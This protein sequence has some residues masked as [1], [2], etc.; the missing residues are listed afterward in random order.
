MDPRSD[1]GYNRLPTLDKCRKL[2]E[3]NDILVKNFRSYIDYDNLTDGRS[4]RSGYGNSSWF[5][6][7]WQIFTEEN[8]KRSAFIRFLMVHSVAREEF[9]RGGIHR[10]EED[11]AGS[12]FEPVTRFSSIT[13]YCAEMFPGRNNDIEKYMRANFV[14]DKERGLLGP[15]LTNKLLLFAPF[16]HG[17]A[18]RWPD[19][20]PELSEAEQDDESP[21][22]GNSDGD[23]TGS[24]D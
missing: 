12:G 1:R 24:G 2:A 20:E 21:Q 17:N 13:E 8:P 4:L 3:F 10:F 16:F 6:P 22:E 7:N 23:A 9:R 14:S 11:F 5:W 18:V 15:V 19:L